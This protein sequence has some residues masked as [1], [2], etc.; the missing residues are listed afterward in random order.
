ML[1]QKGRANRIIGRAMVLQNDCIAFF[2]PFA[3]VDEDVFTAHS[4]GDPGSNIIQ[5][6]RLFN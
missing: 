4:P 6:M 1:K 2:P 5:E 3:D